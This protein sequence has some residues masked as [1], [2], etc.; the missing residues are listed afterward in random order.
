MLVGF[1]AGL[2]TAVGDDVGAE[3]GVPVG[4]GDGTLRR[5]GL[6]KQPRGSR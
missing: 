3:L 6:R 2:G 1:G 4:A 5:R